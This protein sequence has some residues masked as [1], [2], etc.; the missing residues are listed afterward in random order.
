MTSR[1]V[2]K[3]RLCR[4]ISATLTGFLLL[5]V[6]WAMFRGATTAAPD[7][8]QNRTVSPGDVVINEVAWGGTAASSADE[9]IELYNVTAAPITLTGW[10]LAAPDG[11]PSITL[12]GVIP[13]QAYFLLERTDDDTVSDVPADQIYTGGLVNDGETL[14]LTD[15]L[16]ACIDTANAD[17][18]GWPA[19]SGSPNYDSME[20]VDP[21]AP[22]SAE[23]WASNDHVTR[24]GTDADGAPINGT[25]RTRN[26]ARDTPSQPQADLSVANHRP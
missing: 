20:R 19:G 18:D 5:F 2:K 25:P 22:D 7:S 8:P 26:S 11:S 21:I 13:A 12:C 3:K 23:N 17:G 14:L 15:T 4:L 1:P 9:W 6:T 16:G 10:L 24:N